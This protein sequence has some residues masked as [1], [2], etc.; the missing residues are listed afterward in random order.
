MERA[1][2]W[3]QLR[4]WTKD[5]LEIRKVKDSRME[6]SASGFSMPRKISQTGI[7]DLTRPEV[8]AQVMQL[9][10]AGGV[11]LLCSPMV[12]CS[13]LYPPALPSEQGRQIK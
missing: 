12:L 7:P 1:H 6:H 5:E 8:Q 9:G 2:I 11:V 3:D 10:A 13:S 4:D